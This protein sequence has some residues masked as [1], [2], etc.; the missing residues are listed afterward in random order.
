MTEPRYLYD[1]LTEKK[2]R[3][4]TVAECVASD[5]AYSRDKTG[6]IITNGDQ[7]CYVEEG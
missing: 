1:Y 6:I 3:V 4:A 7:R 5:L 2:L